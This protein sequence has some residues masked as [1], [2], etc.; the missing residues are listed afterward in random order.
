MPYPMLADADVFVMPSMADAFGIVYLEAWMYEK[1]VIGARVGAIPDVISEYED[2]LLVE[3]DNY[4]ELAR[5]IELL[6]DH[7]DWSR[8]MGRKGKAKTLANFTQEK[9]AMQFREVFL[10]V[11]G[12]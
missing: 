12:R 1:P 6:L 2:G 7:P 8:A 10:E 9:I 3:L 4:V 11:S 5:K